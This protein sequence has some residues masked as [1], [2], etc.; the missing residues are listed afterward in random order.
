VLKVTA[1]TN[2][3]V[4]GLAYRRGKPYELIQM[5]RAG[6]IALT[7]SQ[8]ILDELAVVLARKFSATPADVAEA[9]GI[10]RGAARVVTPAVTLDVI[11]E[12][13]PDNRILEC[14]VTGGSEYI[15]TGDKD[16]LRLK[17]YDSIRIVNVAN[18][19]A[20]LKGLGRQ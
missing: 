6:E 9:D 16:L 2:V 15:V 4:S 13:P 11:N 20:E 3:L 17:Q 10:V 5:A 1:D 7:V 19:M 8:P 18:F 14:A 12:D